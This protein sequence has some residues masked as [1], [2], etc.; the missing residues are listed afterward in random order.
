MCIGPVW[1]FWFINWLGTERFNALAL[2]KAKEDIDFAIL[3]ESLFTEFICETMP[4]LIIQSINTS[5]TGG[6]NPAFLFSVILS[7]YNTVNGIYK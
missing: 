4:Q 1:N 2:E 6:V 5:L 7:G 3:N